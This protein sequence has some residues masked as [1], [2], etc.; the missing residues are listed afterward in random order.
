MDGVRHLRAIECRQPVVDNRD[1]RAVLPD[2]LERLAPV[3]SAT[4]MTRPLP[5]SPLA[6][7]WRYIG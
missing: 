6:T 2:R 1:L 5:D 4:T 7:P 3:A